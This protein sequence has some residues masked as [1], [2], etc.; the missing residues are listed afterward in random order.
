MAKSTNKTA[1]IGATSILTVLERG[2]HNILKKI[3]VWAGILGNTIIGPLFI[4]ENLNGEIYAEMHLRD[5]ASS[6]L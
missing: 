4:N 1:V 2:I 5:S 3:N 6:D